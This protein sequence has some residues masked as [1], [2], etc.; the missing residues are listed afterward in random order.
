MRK[1]KEYISDVQQ[2]IIELHKLVKWLNKELEQWKIPISN[3]R[4]IIKNFQSTKNVM[5]L[6]GEDMCLYRPNARWEGA[7]EW[8]KTLQGPQLENCRERL[9]FGVRKLLKKIVKQHLHHHMLWW[10]LLAHPKTI[11]SIFSYQTRLNFKWN[12]LLWSDELKKK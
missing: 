2:K 8:P 6:P 11:S 7:F 3:I 9:S 1:T 10:I 5:N 12:W 4:A